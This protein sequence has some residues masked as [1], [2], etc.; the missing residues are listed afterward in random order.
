MKRNKQIA[1]ALALLVAFGLVWSR[2]RIYVWLH[3]SLWPVILLLL[4]LALALYLGL[5][6]L[7]ARRP[8][9]PPTHTD[10]R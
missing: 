8:P 10:D 4:G 1:L 7:S 5:S 2:L 3:G 6:A 9:D